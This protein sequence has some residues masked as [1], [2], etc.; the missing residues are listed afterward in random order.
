MC[1]ES[2]S[3]IGVDLQ[4]HALPLFWV[5]VYNGLCIVYLDSIG[6]IHSGQ[7]LTHGVHGNAIVVNNTLQSAYLLTGY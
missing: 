7:I 5:K 3:T 4:T 1:G 6:Y 2:W